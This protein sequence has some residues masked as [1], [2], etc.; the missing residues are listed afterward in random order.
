MQKTLLLAALTFFALAATAQVQ[1]NGTVYDRMAR[2]GV[3]NVSVM[4]TSGAGT[5]TDSLGRYTIKLSG[6]DSIYFS[7]L[8]KATRKFPVKEIPPGQH[9]DMSLQVSV[10]SLPSVT[11][12]QRSY[13]EDSLQ[14]RNEYRK[15]FEYEPDY[16]AGGGG[17]GFGVG[18]SLDA[19]FSLRKIRRM[20]AFRKRLEWEE[21]EKYID[22]RFTKA[23][24]RRVTGL[25]SPALDS[26]MVWYRPSY[27]TLQIFETEYDYYKYIKDWSLYFEEVWRR[28]YPLQPAFTEQKTSPY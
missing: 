22:H 7:Y 27:E 5:I 8:G 13:R 15:A 16:L 14:N 19:L 21:R 18:I 3:P 17:G 6:T 1:I 26:F 12:R 20:E 24:V 28:K 11:V 2:Y 9:F 25:Q 10:D 4:G 23:I